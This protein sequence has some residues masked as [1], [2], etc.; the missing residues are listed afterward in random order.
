[1]IFVRHA[2]IVAVL[3]GS[4]TPM[5]LG[6]QKPDTATKTE[7]VVGRDDFQQLRWL[8]G[9]W[10]GE[11]GGQPTFY[12]Q[13]RFVDDS[14][15]ASETFSD[16]KFR[17]LKESTRVELRNHRVTLRSGTGQWI[18][19]SL[20]STSAAFRH[21][22]GAPDDFVWQHHAANEWLAVHAWPPGVD[23]PARTATYHMQRVK[24]N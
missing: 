10:R 15:I 3:A 14:T 16:S 5:A 2:V 7:L 18:V 24:G 11:G 6:G 17:T 13:Y 9:S 20:D 1:M 12:V 23:Y 21:L 4:V 22:G 8:S 19:T